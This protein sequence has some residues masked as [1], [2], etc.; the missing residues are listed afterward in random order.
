MSSGLET[1]SAAKLAETL[2]NYLASHPAAA[3]LED[4]RVLFDMR[5]ARYSISESHGRC[6]LQLWSEERNLV[7]TVLEI[8]QRAHSLR[9]MTRRMGAPKP[10]ALEL[11]ATSD[12]RTPTARDS[13]RRNYQRLL[14]RVLTRAF[15]GAKVDGF[16][17]AMDLEH[18]FG[19][20]Y[21]R[22][23]LLRGTA[24][25]AVIGIGGAE[26]STAIDGILTLG[27][28]WLDYC[29]QKADGRRH[30]GGLKVIVPAGAWRTTAER[31]A[32]LNSSAAFELFALDERTEELE[33]IDFRDCG[34]QTARLIHAFSGESALERC[35]A[36]LGKVMAFLP[37]GSQHRVELR[38]RSASEVGLLLHGLEFARVRNGP[39]AHSFTHQEEITFGAGANETPLTPETED[40]CRAL[41][42]RL[43]ASRHPGGTHA[44]PLFRMQPER[45][46][47]SEF[48]RSLGELLPILRGE[49]VYSQVPALSC[50][51]RGMLDLLA[52]DRNGRLCVIE[53]KADEDLQLP[54]QAL[55]YW[56]RV[57]ALNADR[58][59]TPMSDRLLSA[60]EREGYFQGMEL[61]DQPPRLILVAPALRIHPANLPVLRYL[62]PEVDWELIALGEH[63]RDELKIVFR[64][65]SADS[66]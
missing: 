55:D 50:G 29:R 23:R 24:A 30:F 5:L 64:K 2:E 19:P 51:D 44:D 66:R 63:W 53:L 17:S 22:G 20:A 62:S 15:L 3:L 36:G 54:M 26:S 49:S 28:L 8:Q 46:L 25:D 10:Q 13:A 6:L 11:V 38:P 35:G 60:F 37:D 4:G 43:F 42:E 9:V 32:W 65:R 21:V 14:E 47:E 40:T 41:C 58:Q 1:P 16:R 45:W 33:A 61:S 56:I 31:M 57:R 18:S 7:R 39:S 27:V 59:R 52:A 12:R 48:R 34:N